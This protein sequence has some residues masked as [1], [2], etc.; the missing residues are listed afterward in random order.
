MLYKPQNNLARRAVLA[1][2]VVL[3]LLCLFLLGS[4]VAASQDGPRLPPGDQGVNPDFSTDPVQDDVWNWVDL[5]NVMT[6]NLIADE[7]HGAAEVGGWTH[8]TVDDGVDGSVDLALDGAGKAHISYDAGGLY[9]ATQA[10]ADWDRV[11]IADHAYHTSIDV[12]GQGYEHI[13]FFESNL[14]HDTLKYAYEDSDGW[15]VGTFN[16]SGLYVGRYNDLA[17]DGNDQA[18]MVFSTWRC[19]AWSGGTCIHWDPD[20]LEYMH[21]VGDQWQLM[22]AGY[23]SEYD[24]LALDDDG[25]AHMSFYNAYLD[26]LKYTCYDILVVAPASYTVDESADVGRYASV[27][28]DSQYTP[29]RPHMA[30]YDADNDDLKYAYATG[31]DVWHLA[32]YSETVD[33]GGVGGDVGQYASLALDGDGYP[34]ISYYDAENDDLKYAFQDDDGWQIDTV[35]S[36]GNVG[37]WSS[38]ALDQEGNV[39]IAYYDATN[40]TVKYAYKSGNGSYAAYLPLIIR[41]TDATTETWNH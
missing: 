15:H 9:C 22:D 6:E 21:P 17:I 3:L 19:M 41:G 31:P 10:G 40:D 18:H 28:V 30:Y 29:P 27:D 23:S 25:D 33:T 1:M 24:S 7:A 2:V 32:W 5:G 20:K 38:L 11:Q 34:H 8:E 12:D 4:Q 39:H 13:L 14:K 26:I 16:I 35:D 36:E 37:S